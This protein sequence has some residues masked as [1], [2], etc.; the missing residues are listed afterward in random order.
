MAWRRRKQRKYYYRSRREGDRVKTDYFGTGPLAWAVAKMDAEARDRE[1]A[2]A[3]EEKTA[4]KPF[5]D[6]DGFVRRLIAA[7]NE[8]LRAVLLA[9]GF[10]LHQRGTWR[11]K[12]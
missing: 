5:E 11:R 8:L 4:R 7:S 1:Q 9:E 6:A 3:D 10:C 12:K 2:Q